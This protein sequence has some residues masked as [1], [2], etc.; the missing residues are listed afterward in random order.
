VNQAEL[1]QYM[2][3]GG[4]AKVLGSFKRNEEAGAAH[5][6][7]YAA[8]VYRRFVQPLADAISIYATEVKRGVQARAKVLMRKQDPLLMSVTTIRTL[9][10]ASLQQKKS[11]PTAVS[12]AIGETLYGETL[13]EAFEN[14][15]PDLYYTLVRDFER[16]MTKS[17]RHRLTVFKQQAAKNGIHLPVWSSEDKLAVGTVLIYLAREIGLIDITEAME[18]GK[19]VREYKLMPE[20]AG[21]LD[22][23]K[24]F[25]AGISPIS[26]PCVEPPIPWTDANTGGYHTP[27]MRRVAPCCIRGR[28]RVEDLS[29]VPDIPLRALNALQRRAWAIN[30]RVLKA[31]DDVGARFD[32]GEVLAQAELPKPHRP[33]WLDDDMDK[34]SLSPAQLAEFSVWKAEMREW[35]TTNKERGVQWGRYYEAL[36]VARMFRGKPFWFVYQ[37]DFRGRCY[38]NTRGVSPQGSDLQKALLQAHKGNPISTEAARWWFFIAGANRF[39]YDKATLDERF[40][41]TVERCAMIRAIAADPLSNRQWTEADNP[42]Q[43]LAW[44]FEYADY[45]ADPAIFVSHLALGQDGS[46]N[47]LQHFSAMLRDEVGGRATNLVPAETQQDIYRLVSDETAR[48]LGE[49]TGMGCVYLDRWRRHA[50]SRDLVKRSVMT[51]PYGSTRF[52]CG[53]FIFKEY[54]SKHKAPEFAPP[55]YMKASRALS[56][57]VWDAIGN[58]VVKAREAMAWLQNA[59]DELIAAGVQEIYWRSPSGFMIRQRYGKY[60]FIKVESRLSQTVRIRPTI[61]QELEEPCPRRHRNGIAPNFIH[62][63]DAG[64][65]HFLIVE[66]DEQVDHMAFIHDDYGTDAVY[67]ETLHKLIRATFVK[68]YTERQPIAEFASQWGISAAQPTPGTLDL[69]QVLDSKYFFA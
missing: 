26:L 46:C 4:R 38:A 10:D 66:A 34:A 18:R 57:P 15:E 55:E 7:P 24:G 58:V 54:V 40:A 1:E 41:W 59:S 2:V 33:E 56:V 9:L 22:H 67:T 32:V 64:H 69:N 45:F 16:R 62:G 47:G 51:L 6:N 42:F 17:E 68:M 21:M 43:F 5:N 61:Q 30:E 29:D 44:C 28:P 63:C 65:M 35:Y 31:V 13:L 48:L 36:R 49:G 12:R 20:I 3:D 14:I 27:V 8:A 19:T 37:F 53:E 25:V 60:E 39:G 50:L 11:A 52:S 23:I